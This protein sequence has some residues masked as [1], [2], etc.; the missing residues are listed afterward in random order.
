MDIHRIQTETI[1][2]FKQSLMKVCEKA[3]ENRVL[4]S[5]NLSRRV[6]DADFKT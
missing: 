5:E 2:P 1:E 3:E 6:S 4:S